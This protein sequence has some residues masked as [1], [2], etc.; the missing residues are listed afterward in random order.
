MGNSQC[1][2][3]DYNYVKTFESANIRTINKNNDNNI[4]ISCPAQ[5][6]LAETNPE[7]I[8]ASKQDISITFRKIIQSYQSIVLREIVKGIISQKQ[9]QIREPISFK[10]E[11]LSLINLK[12]INQFY[13][14]NEVI[15]NKCYPNKV[16]KSIRKKS[17]HIKKENEFG[18]IRKQKFFY[19]G[20]ISDNQMN[21][22]G[23]QIWN[24]KS[25]YIGN[26]KDSAYNGIGKYFGSTKGRYYGYFYNNAAFNYGIYRDI[27]FL[28]EGYWTNDV[29]D[30]FGIE[31]NPIGTYKGSYKLGTKSGFGSFEYSNGDIYIGNFKKD[32]FNGYGKFFFKDGRVYHG[33]FYNNDMEGFGEFSWPN[34]NK[35]IGLYKENKKHGF[36]I[37]LWRKSSKIYIGEWNEGMQDGNGKL[38][39]RNNSI[40]G[41]WIEGKFFMKKAL[42][43]NILKF[44]NIKKN[45]T[46]PLISLPIKRIHEILSEISSD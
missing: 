12:P 11:A 7:N 37:Y 36:G 30:I 29:P 16:S 14:K 43:K 26:F 35:Y 20:W 17:G 6:T 23:I 27:N 19:Y 2:R 38:I 42:E 32:L 25:Y 21:G 22:F 3:N 8:V 39:L 46:P 13:P 5:T 18:E 33:E 1:N 4:L 28:Y 9:L 34:G 24:D 15:T 41:L 45:K 31:E 10:R 40:S 44:L